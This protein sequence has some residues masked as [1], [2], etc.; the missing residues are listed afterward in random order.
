MAVV[1]TLVT[2][3]GRTALTINF[4]AIIAVVLAILTKVFLTSNTVATTIGTGPL[5]FAYL[6]LV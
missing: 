4:I 2:R 3:L 5:T 1:S 6:A